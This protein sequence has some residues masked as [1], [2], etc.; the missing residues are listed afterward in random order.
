MYHINVQAAFFYKNQHVTDQCED[1]APQEDIKRKGLF[2]IGYWYPV[3]V[4]KEGILFEDGQERYTGP[5]ED[6]E[7][8]GQPVKLQRF[9]HRL[10]S[11]RHHVLHSLIRRA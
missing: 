3:V 11:R 8:A 4:G 7:R 6:T 5:H 10:Q 2:G 9:I 1:A